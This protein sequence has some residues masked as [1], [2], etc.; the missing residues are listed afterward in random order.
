LHNANI[1]NIKGYMDGPIDVW[2]DCYK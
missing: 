1:D 2:W